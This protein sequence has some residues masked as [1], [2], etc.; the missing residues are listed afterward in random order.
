MGAG[1]IV[2][3][4][5]QSSRMQAIDWLNIDLAAV[6]SNCDLD[7]GAKITNETKCLS[8]MCQINKVSASKRR[9]DEV[10]AALP[11][12]EVPG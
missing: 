9:F 8:M 4:A 7:D 11:S 3:Q 1:N 2:N 10:T 5:R 6:C 12:P